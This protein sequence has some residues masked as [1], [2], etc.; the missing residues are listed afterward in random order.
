MYQCLI[1]TK[2]ISTECLNNE[3]S[4]TEEYLDKIKASLNN[5]KTD[6][7]FSLKGTDKEGDT[8]QTVLLLPCLI[9]TFQHFTSETAQD[10]L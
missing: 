1:S 4:W 9:N 10:L 5:S 2:V 6:T 3:I 7:H 8:S